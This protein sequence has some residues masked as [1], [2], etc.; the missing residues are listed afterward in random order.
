MQDSKKNLINMCLCLCF[1]SGTSVLMLYYAS[2]CLNVIMST[3]NAFLNICKYI[4]KERTQPQTHNRRWWEHGWTHKHCCVLLFCSILGSVDGF[5]RCTWDFVVLP[6]PFVVCLHA[7]WFCS[8]CNAKKNM[9][10][11]SKAGSYTPE[12]CRIPTLYTHIL[13]IYNFVKSLAG[14]LI[15]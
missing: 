13:Y 9:Q 2:A 12:P 11:L 10:P 7:Y 4:W 3:L 6:C 8:S 1:Y 14:Q 15:H 5:S